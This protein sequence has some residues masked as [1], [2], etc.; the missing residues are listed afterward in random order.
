[1]RASS[2]YFADE[3]TLSYQR[4]P[5][6]NSQRPAKRARRTHDAAIS[7]EMAIDII[8]PSVAS[9]FTQAEVRSLL[10]P[11]SKSVQRAA[12]R[13]PVITV[14]TGSQRFLYEI[15]K[16][17]LTSRVR[18]RTNDRTSLDV[19]EDDD[20]DEEGFNIARILAPFPNNVTWSPFENAGPV[21]KMGV[22]DQYSRLVVLVALT[23]EQ[24]LRAGL[25]LEE[26]QTAKRRENVNLSRLSPRAD[27]EKFEELTW[28]L[29]K[30]TVIA[31][32]ENGVLKVAVMSPADLNGVGSWTFKSRGLFEL[33]DVWA[34]H[35]LQNVS[36]GVSWTDC[37]ATQELFAEINEAVE[38]YGREHSPLVP[39]G[40]NKVVHI[41]VTPT[42]LPFIRGVSKFVPSADLAD[43]P[44][45]GGR[46]S[47]LDDDDMSIPLEMPKYQWLPAY[48]DLDANKNATIR[49][50]ISGLRPASAFPELYD[51]FARLF[52]LAVPRI[53]GVLAYNRWFRRRLQAR[54]ETNIMPEL[55]RI[56]LSGT[57]LQ[58]MIVLADYVLQPGESFNSKWFL[59]GMFHEHI[60]VTCLYILSRDEE[61]E[62]ADILFRRWFFQEERDYLREQFSDCDPAFRQTWT[63]A[64]KPLGSIATPAHRSIVVPATHLINLHE[65]K[66]T[67]NKTARC[68]TL[69]FFVVDPE[70]RIVS[71]QEVP[72]QK[73]LFTSDEVLHHAT[74]M[75]RERHRSQQDL[76]VYLDYISGII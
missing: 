28:D 8:M 70:K 23:E 27:G 1:M 63:T 13:A 59:R 29:D 38:N 10:V 11:V 44:V 14:N 41:Y 68:R 4:H 17:E 55:E 31:P 57:S 6:K 39:P 61:I 71:T 16:S 5:M 72:D 18:H 30:V 20:S 9:F 24:I 19:D 76:A 15:T 37:T 56:D 36:E 48:F 3:I 49:T 69:V 33:G 32:F 60:E 50:D 43:P 75:M 47:Q 40:A 46:T 45:F 35:Q 12:A 22:Y 73:D 58:V 66:N 54:K 74:E 21:L 64:F 53:E 65:M 7:R 62:G 51:C 26:V 52:S 25:G 2:N 67:S 42:L 34:K